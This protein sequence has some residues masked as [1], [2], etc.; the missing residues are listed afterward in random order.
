[1][2]KPE[3]EAGLYELGEVYSSSGKVPVTDTP[4]TGK[5]VEVAF[6]AEATEA[7]ASDCKSVKGIHE[8]PCA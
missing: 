3:R 8:E 1:M 5:H 6:K 2:A 4:Y 7:N